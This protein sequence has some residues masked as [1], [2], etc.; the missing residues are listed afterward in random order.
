MIIPEPPR[1]RGLNVIQDRNSLRG[2]KRGAPNG[3]AYARR[4]PDEYGGNNFI[5]EKD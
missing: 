3:G 2:N 4:K 5:M 1:L